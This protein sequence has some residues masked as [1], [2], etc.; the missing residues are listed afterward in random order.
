MPVS[1]PS[2]I[3]ATLLIH[4]IGAA[5]ASAL[6]RKQ[7]ALPTAN[8]LAVIVTDAVAADAAAATT[9][10]VVVHR[11][12]GPLQRIAF[13]HRLYEPLHYV[14]LPYGE[15]GWHPGLQHVHSPTQPARRQHAAAASS[16]Q[17][18]RLTRLEYGAYRLMVRRGELNPILYSRRLGQEWIVSTYAAHESSRLDWIR[19]HQKQLRTETFQVWHAL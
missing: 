16:R 4:K 10:Q 7:Y 13:T 18:D 11:R 15:E 6:Q 3:E 1:V 5:E 14:L 19:F 12:G 2:I 9:H 8:E 17:R